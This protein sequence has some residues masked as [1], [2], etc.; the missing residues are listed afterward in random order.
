[1]K[2]TDFAVVIP[3][4]NGANTLELLLQR[5]TSVFQQT[6]KSFQV[7]M[8][9]DGSVDKSWEAMLKLKEKFPDKII[10]IK[11]GRNFGEH[12]AVLCGLANA[13]ADFYITIDDD[14]QMPPEEILLMIEKQK[15]ENSDAVYGVLENKQHS[16][17]RNWASNLIYFFLKREYG[18]SQNIS[19]FRLL[20]SRVVQKLIQANG[21]FIYIDGLL[22]WTTKNISFVKVK[23]DERKT[24]NSGYSFSKLF[25]LSFIVLFGFTTLPL[26][27]ITFSGFMITILSL[28]G[29]LNAV[30]EK[31]Y[32]NIPIGYTSIIV[33]LFFGI[34]LIMLVLGIVGDYL[35]KIYINS[36]HKP[37]YFIEE[38]K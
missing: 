9:D 26:M 10:A 16:F 22:W 28:A 8:V 17:W 30:Y 32:Y 4:F 15:N 13:H 35:R 21:S 18:F 27:L 2:R 3:V 12:H 19:T 20:T 37:A 33:T 25:R 14:L 5:I 31:F 29:I 24:N 38:I 36:N 6:G 34:G 11:L 7:V 23:H 1:M